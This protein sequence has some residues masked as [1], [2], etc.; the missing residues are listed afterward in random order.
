MQAEAGETR[1][2][3]SGGE[4]AEVGVDFGLASHSGAAAAVTVAHEVAE[5][6]FDL[7]RVDR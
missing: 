3:G 5:L 1:E 6:A 2:V 7:G 4:E